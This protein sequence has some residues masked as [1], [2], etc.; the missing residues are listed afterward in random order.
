MHTALRSSLRLLILHALVCQAASAQAGADSARA[1]SSRILR[2]VRVEAAR[3]PQPADR[4]PWA[5]STLD[6]R[7]LRRGQ[8]T[9]GLDE[10][11][12]DLP[13]VVVSNRYN[14][15]LDQRLSIRGAGSR[16]NFGLRG[17]KVLLDGIP[18]SLPDGQSQLTNVDLA[19]IGRVEVLR[20]AASS[21]HGNGSGGVLAFTT[22]LT[23]PDRL[24]ASVRATTGSFGMNKLQLRTSGRTGPFIGAVSASRTTV[25]GFRQYS[26]ADLR[27]LGGA[28]DQALNER[29]TLSWRAGVA[30]TPLALNPGALTAAE[31]AI[32]P[33]TAALNNTRRGAQRSVSQRYLSLRAHKDEGP[34]TWSASLFGQRRFIDNP[35]ATAPPAPAAPT[36]GVR[37][38]IDRRVTGL[39]L[40]ASRTVAAAWEPRL[41]VGLDVQRSHDV[42]RNERTTG[43]WIV[44]PTDT[45]F[46][47]QGE[48]VV[49]VGPSAQLQLSP[50]PKV[51]L[52]MG[53]RWDRLSFRVEDHFTGDGDDDSGERVMTAASGHVGA[54]WQLAPAFSPYANIGTAFETPTTTELNSR[55]DGLGGF[56]DALGPQRIVSAEVGAR[57]RVGERVTYEMAYFDSRAGDAIVQYLESGGR[58][59]FRNAGRTRSRGVELGFA[60][61]LTPSF[62]LRGAY[63]GADHRFVEYRIPSATLPV[64]ARD[65]L[66]GN[67]LAGI[68]KENWRVALQFAHAGLVVDAEQTMQGAAW[69]DDANS[70]RVA[71]W[72][73]G[74][75]NLRTSWRGMVL[76]RSVEPFVAL[77]NA[78]DER[79]VGAVTLNGFGGRVLEPAPGRNW[80]LGIEIGSPVLR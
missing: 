57:G 69:G 80:Y 5:V 13:G 4:V 71:D 26:R 10:A 2:A 25:D 11:V 39:R 42:R 37:N 54:V 24:G 61:V 15:A 36:N 51:A 32:N 46:L 79:Y 41:S 28:V 67:R 66:D 22:D 20:G 55:Q 1:D 53:A 30:E 43:G 63:T 58:A 19:S 31:Y 29:V 12:S 59:Y 18:Q 52:S 40:D 33:D 64:P 23:A 72:G 49:S 14:Y 70:V 62:T 45:T 9:L 38:T 48:T 50:A 21:L 75:L 34:V 6:A 73:R 74:L 44:A 3:T 47:F 78:L 65:T 7:A 56:N 8:A 35:L 16:A 76:G 60:A 17:V 68:P 77:Q 27:Q